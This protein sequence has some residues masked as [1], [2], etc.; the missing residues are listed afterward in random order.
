MGLETSFPVLYTR[1]VLTGLISLERLTEAMSSAPRRIFRLPDA[2][3]D[4][5]EVDLDTPY[6]IRSGDFLSKGRSTPFEGMEVRGKVLKTYYNGYLVYD[7]TKEKA[8]A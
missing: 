3:L 2:P 6:V 5:I 8:G 4:R 1:L 7:S